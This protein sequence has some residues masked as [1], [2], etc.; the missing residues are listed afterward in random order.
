MTGHRNDSSTSRVNAQT[1]S[2]RIESFSMF[3]EM[4][5]V[6]TILSSQ[7]IHKLSISV[8][9]EPASEASAVDWTLIS[10]IVASSVALCALVALTVVCCRWVAA[11]ILLRITP[12]SER[13]FQKRSKSKRTEDSRGRTELRAAE[14]SP[15]LRRDQSFP[16]ARIQR[17]W[18][19]S[20]GYGTRVPEIRRFRRCRRIRLQQNHPEKRKAANKAPALASRRGY[21]KFCARL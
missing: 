6:I 3:K 18:A 10:A 21:L 17:V 9:I 15:G 19:S 1:D 16:G 4:T 20:G 11:R 12:N 14:S 8:S 5:W 7:R 2:C 13:P